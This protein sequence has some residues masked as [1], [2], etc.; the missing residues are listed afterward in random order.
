[1]L[2][3]NQSLLEL[4]QNLITAIREKRSYSFNQSIIEM[5]DTYFYNTASTEETFANL[6]TKDSNA[7]KNLALELDK[8]HEEQ[9]IIGQRLWPAQG[10][11]E[12]HMG[13]TFLASSLDGTIIAAS[14]QPPHGTIFLFDSAGNC[15]LEIGAA[16]FN[17]ALSFDG[18]YVLGK[19]KDRDLA[20]WEAKT[21]L[22]IG[23]FK[24][25]ITTN[26]ILITEDNRFAIGAGGKNGTVTIWNVSDG[27]IHKRIAARQGDITAIASSSDSTVVAT[28]GRHDNSVRFWSVQTG[29]LLATGLPHSNH[30]HDMKFSRDG[31][32]LITSSLESKIKVWNIANQS[33]LYEIGQEDNTS[34][35]AISPDGHHF[36]IIAYDKVSVRSLLDGNE[37]A[38]LGSVQDEI[39]N[40]IAFSNFGDIIVAGST[41][42]S[43]SWCA[44]NTTS[45]SLCLSDIERLQMAPIDSLQEP[46]IELLNRILAST[47]L[48]A[49]Q[50]WLLSLLRDIHACYANQTDPQP[51]TAPDSLEMTL[52]KGPKPI[53][54]PITQQ[55]ADNELA[56]L[57]FPTSPDQLRRLH[58]ILCATPLPK[59]SEKQ[60]RE[61]ALRLAL[62]NSEDAYH[63]LSDAATSTASRSQLVHNIAFEH[64][65]S[66]STQELIDIIC[67]YWAITRDEQL[68][69]LLRSKHWVA[70]KSE[71]TQVLT[72]LLVGKSEDL[73][74]PIG[75]KV[76][77]LLEAC[78]DS[79]DAIKE[80]ALK[81]VLHLEPERISLLTP[82]IKNSKLDAAKRDATEPEQYN[83]KTRSLGQQEHVI[84]ATFNSDGKFLATTNC[85]EGVTTL[86][87]STPD[88]E[89]IQVQVREKQADRDSQIICNKSIVQV[90]QIPECKL[91]LTIETDSLSKF[92]F[93]PLEPILAVACSADGKN[94][95]QLWDLQ[96][97]RLTRCLN[98][99]VSPCQNIIFSPDGKYIVDASWGFYTLFVWDYLTGELIRR[100]PLGGAYGIA[101]D[102]SDSTIVT[103]GQKIQRRSI[104]GGRLSVESELCPGTDSYYGSC[105]FSASGNYLAVIQYPGTVE[106]R[107]SKTLELI[108]SFRLNEA[109]TAIAID[110]CNNVFAVAEEWGEI[111][112]FSFDERERIAQIKLPSEESIVSI[113]FNPCTN[114][115]LGISTTGVW[116]FEN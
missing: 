96:T 92:A 50:R 17:F 53:G 77:Y 86:I 105:I 47:W 23:K 48:S 84:A 93:H 114:S 55:W 16:Q 90:W 35:I 8:R 15:Y 42:G 69:W 52:R 28:S 3:T 111:E 57:Q 87:I 66:V 107:L 13:W 45:N 103:T 109:P 91:L 63:L 85:L 39:K 44:E 94:Q 67:E 51:Q 32:K 115:L 102:P 7:I 4:E 75:T 9:S 33:L 46:D 54:I 41:T 27:N 89:N 74:N 106:I 80:R 49:K 38:S 12:C 116:I 14:T 76:K 2:Y 25:S 58:S 43:Y 56:E 81:V 83:Y 36:C 40:T 11:A 30:I 18:K 61:A 59:I 20:L 101:F 24:Q 10:K 113:A 1:M 97:L 6:S 98:H 95:I 88:F 31:T 34:G 37:I 112:I 73:Q 99:L 78:E 82:K 70:T 110:P 100:L 65:Q 72:K 108:S 22:C 64:L 60:R 68:E 21:G 62:T 19:S 104:P 26:L 79:N 29:E 5:C 71:R